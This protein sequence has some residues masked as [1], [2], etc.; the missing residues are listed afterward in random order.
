MTSDVTPLFNALQWHTLCALADT[1]IPADDYPSAIEAGV[2]HYLKRIFSTDLRG[3]LA[4]YRLCLDLLNEETDML[5]GASFPNLSV[6][7]REELLARLEGGQHALTW[8]LHPRYFLH[9]L[10]HL[11]AEGYYSDPG[12]GGNRG[13]ISWKMIG[14][15]VTA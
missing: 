12:N 15:E 1:I 3:Q 7:Q 9:R 2:D 14:F 11:V 4:T 6:E 5:Y 8:P 13:A 10:Y